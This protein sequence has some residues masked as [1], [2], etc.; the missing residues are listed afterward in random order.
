MATTV[1]LSCSLECFAKG[2][3]VAS[4]ALKNHS[5]TAHVGGNSIHCPF[6]PCACVLFV[7]FLSLRGC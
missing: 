3:S 5:L 2:A 4:R 1:L 7:S 6:L